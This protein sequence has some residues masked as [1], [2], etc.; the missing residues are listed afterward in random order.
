T[1][2]AQ[3]NLYAPARRQRT[4]VRWRRKIGDLQTERYFA[5]RDEWARVH[6]QATIARG[7]STRSRQ[8]HLGWTNGQRERFA[9]EWRLGAE[10]LTF[11]VASDELMA[12]N[13]T[14]HVCPSEAGGASGVLDI[15]LLRPQEG[16]DVTALPL[17]EH[18][19]A[20][21]VIRAGGA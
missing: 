1:P 5:G 17:L 6:S 19:T 10:P 3:G 2:E 7:K 21:L 13:Q 4:S 20:R 8:V 15:A 12:S 18:P 14:I 9:L 11:A 16:I